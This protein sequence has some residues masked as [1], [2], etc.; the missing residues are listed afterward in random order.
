MFL[1]TVSRQCDSDL[2]CVCAEIGEHPRSDDDG[3]QRAKY[4]ALL[5]FTSRSP[6]VRPFHTSPSRRVR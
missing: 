5:A 4:I 1:V 2:A 6:I 3:T